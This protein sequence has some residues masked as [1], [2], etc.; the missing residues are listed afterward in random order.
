MADVGA[1]DRNRIERLHHMPEHRIGQQTFLDDKR[2]FFQRRHNRR[3][4]RGFQHAHVIA[5]D[6]AWA[7]EFAQMLDAANREANAD[8]FQGMNHIR[9]ALNPLRRGVSPVFA[10]DAR[11][12]DNRDEFRVK[13]QR[14]QPPRKRGRRRGARLID[15]VFIN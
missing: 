8:A 10:F 11:F 14:R 5:D 3:K 1:R 2:G 12:P 7:V 13:R 6:D 9:A 15:A 4:N